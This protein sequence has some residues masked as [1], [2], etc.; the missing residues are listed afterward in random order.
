MGSGSN[1]GRV[2]WGRVL[3]YSY[4]IHLRTDMASGC[5]PNVQVRMLVALARM[6]V[7]NCVQFRTCFVAQLWSAIASTIAHESAASGRCLPRQLSLR[8]APCDAAAPPLATGMA[9]RATP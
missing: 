2:G 9:A 1:E 7:C 4:G 5:L 3:A 6:C 8:F